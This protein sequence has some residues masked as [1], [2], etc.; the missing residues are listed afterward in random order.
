VFVIP[1]FSFAAIILLSGLLQ[2]ASS[3][4]ECG[5]AMHCTAACVCVLMEQTT[6]DDN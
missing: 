2:S 1:F 3:G 6:F 5:T 4:D